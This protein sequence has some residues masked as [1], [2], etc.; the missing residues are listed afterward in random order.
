MCICVYIYIYM[1]V[2]MYIHK[3][4]YMCV[5]PSVPPSNFQTTNI[6]STN[7]TFIWD[8]LVSQANGIIKL[9]V[10]NCIGDDNVVTVS[11]HQISIS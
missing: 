4:V 6:T 9:Y 5:A 11:S 3:Y 10:I 1:Y 7:I 2:C 8:P